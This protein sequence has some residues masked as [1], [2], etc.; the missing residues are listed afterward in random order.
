MPFRSE[1]HSTMSGTEIS[2]LLAGLEDS[3]RIFAQ[4][5]D[6]PLAVLDAALDAA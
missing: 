3:E 4:F 6:T 5:A 1:S 2:L